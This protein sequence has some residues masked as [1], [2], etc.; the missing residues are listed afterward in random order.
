MKKNTEETYQI[1]HPTIKEITI[2]DLFVLNNGDIYE[3]VRYAKFGSDDPYPFGFVYKELKGVQNKTPQPQHTEFDNLDWYSNKLTINLDI[4]DLNVE[5]K[6]L[7][8]KDKL[9]QI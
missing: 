1:D 5:S 6:L 9:N 3:F 8:V 2:G 4:P 7:S